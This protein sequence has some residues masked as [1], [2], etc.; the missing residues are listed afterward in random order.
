M[1]DFDSIVAVG[2]DQL[3]LCQLRFCGAVGGGHS[4][5]EVVSNLSVFRP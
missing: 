5:S 2:F 1:S 3:N 4:P